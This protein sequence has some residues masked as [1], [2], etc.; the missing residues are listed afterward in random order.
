MMLGPENIQRSLF[1]EPDFEYK[2]AGELKFLVKY[3][4]NKNE[5]AIRSKIEKE[6]QKVKNREKDGK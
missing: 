5:M 2:Q 3:W 1:I 6:T 4:G